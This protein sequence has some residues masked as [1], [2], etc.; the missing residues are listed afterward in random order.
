MRPVSYERAANIAEALETTPDTALLAGGTTLVDL[1]KLDVMTPRRLIDITALPASDPALAEVRASERGGVII[2]G[3]ARM[4]DVAAHPLV[5]D[6]YPVVAEAL[7]QGAS[8]QLR[9]MATI[10][11]N[12]LQRTRCVYF[13]DVTVAECNKREPGSG[14]AARLGVHRTAAVL[15]ASEACIAT[16]PS[17]LAVALVALDAVV[18]LTSAGGV[19][20]VNANDFFL[21]PGDTPQRETV[22]TPGELI[23]AIELPPLPVGAR[24]HYL[25]VRDRESYEFALA[26][27][28]VAIQIADGMI[29]WA[30]LALGGVG[31]V[32]WRA[33]AA[34]AALID[35]PVTA[36]VFAK[37]AVVAV[38]GAA[39]LTQNAFKVTLAQ[40]TLERALAT[41]AG[42]IESESESE[43]ERS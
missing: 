29:A 28:A 33:A 42:L 39:P 37:A 14:C 25:K 22:V 19:R 21:L 7:L 30:R 16:H 3:L 17:D 32:P 43:R 26:A 36:A 12:L 10:G 40:R 41:A 2:G 13:R 18:H 9:N 20:L 8:A 1:M 11:G 4:S 23:T 27:A 6:G 35:Q 15:G 31:T 34:E 38:A 24:S 5:R